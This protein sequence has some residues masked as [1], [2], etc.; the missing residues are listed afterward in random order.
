MWNSFVSVPGLCLFIYLTTGRVFHL[1][2][3]L[4]LCSHSAAAIFKRVQPTVRHRL[5]YITLFVWISSLRKAMLTSCY[6][7]AQGGGD[8][9]SKHVFLT[10][11]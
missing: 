8:V 3:D 7:G 5:T 2:P 9:W 1:L 4:A 11:K 6:F 10:K